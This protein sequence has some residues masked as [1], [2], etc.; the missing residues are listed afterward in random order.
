MRTPCN[1]YSSRESRKSCVTVVMFSIMLGVGVLLTLP[2]EAAGHDDEASTDQTCPASSVGCAALHLR[3]A[4]GSYDC[5]Q[6]AKSVL[7]KV[8]WTISHEWV[9]SGGDGSSSVPFFSQLSNLSPLPLPNG[10]VFETDKVAPI[11]SIGMPYRGVAGDAGYSAILVFA[12]GTTEKEQAWMVAQ[13]STRHN[14]G[15]ARVYTRGW[16]TDVCLMHS[17]HE[18][19]LLVYDMHHTTQGVLLLHALGGVLIL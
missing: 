3:D 1:A 8:Q 13:F 12:N 4:V 6:R 17:L 5:S 9:G 19:D 14:G 18:K 11:V 7:G 10:S 16:N 15:V 2:W